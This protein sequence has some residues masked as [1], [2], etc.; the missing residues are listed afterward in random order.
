MMEAFRAERGPA[1]ND[2]ELTLGQ[3]SECPIHLSL[4][5]SF[6]VTL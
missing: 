4:N 3:A 6:C 5:P 2:A 1:A